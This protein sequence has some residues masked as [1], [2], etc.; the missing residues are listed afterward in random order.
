MFA[1]ELLKFVELFRNHF[2]L[3]SEPVESLEG[4]ITVSMWL[5]KESFHIEVLFIHPSNIPVLYQHHMRKTLTREL[6]TE[7][8][9]TDWFTKVSQSVVVEFGL[10]YTVA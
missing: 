8:F 1:E 5:V 2:W 10:C 3:C 9:H 4:L 6:Y 7:C